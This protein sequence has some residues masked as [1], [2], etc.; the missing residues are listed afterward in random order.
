MKI[1]EAKIQRGRDLKAMVDADP[2]GLIS[3]LDAEIQTNL[4]WAIGSR[5]GV[6]PDGATLSS[7]DRYQAL[8]EYRDW[9]TE[10]IEA[11]GAELLRKQELAE[12]RTVDA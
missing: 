11:G 7:L 1:D 4:D 3:K 5:R 6:T 8:K 10:E 9:I 2:G 12:R